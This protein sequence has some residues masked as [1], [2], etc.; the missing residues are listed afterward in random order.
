MIGVIS[1]ARMT[2]SRLPGKVLMPLAGRP[3]LHYHI[4]G[5][6]KAGLPIVIATTTNPSDDPVVAFCKEIGVPTYRGSELDVLARFAGA[7]EV[8]NLD[9]VV[10]V[11]SDCPLIDGRLIKDALDVF[12][13]D[14]QPS[15]YISNC[16]Q[17]TFPRGF[18]FEV[19]SSVALQKMNLNA[20][21]EFEREHV[22]PFIWKSHPELFKMIHVKQ[23]NDASDLRLTVDEPADFELLKQLIERYSAHELQHHEVVALMRTHPELID[24]NSKIHQRSIK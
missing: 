22:T 14:L 9:Y 4:E 5:L 1:Q 7:A 3:M 17:R 8:F 16:H 23:E 2:S 15:T 20:Q 6:R 10:R 11:T 12:K 19:F 21:L 13:E 24:I 18:D